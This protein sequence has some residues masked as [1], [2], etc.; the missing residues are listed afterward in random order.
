VVFEPPLPE[1]KVESITRLGFGLLNKVVHTRSIYGSK[2]MMQIILF[3]DE[4]F[5]DKDID[6]F[7]FASPILLPSHGRAVTARTRHAGRHS[8]FG[9][10][11]SRRNI[12]PWLLSAL[13]TQQSSLSCHAPVCCDE[14]QELEMLSDEEV[15]TRAIEALKRIFG[16]R[17]LRPTKTAC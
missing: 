12:P 16:E 17:T 9:A 15:S 11:C 1:R 13:A 7:G 3:F 2:N 5:W 14:R 6:L 4:V 10:S 8:S